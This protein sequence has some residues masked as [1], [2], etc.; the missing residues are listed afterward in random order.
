LPKNPKIS[1]EKSF[2]IKCNLLEKYLYF[3]TAKNLNHSPDEHDEGIPGDGKPHRGVV[4]DH[5]ISQNEQST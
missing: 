1:T 5:S 2:T 4:F 3:L